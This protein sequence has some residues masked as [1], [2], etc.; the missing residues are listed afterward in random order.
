MIV[1]GCN[2]FSRVSEVFAEHFGSV[3][4]EKHYLLGHDAGASLL[5]DGRLV[6]AV[7]EERLN[8]EKKTTDFPFHSVS[9]CLEQA[10]LRFSDIDL[11][12]IPWNFSPEVFDE[13]LAGIT[14]APMAP[15]AKLDLIAGIGK[16]FTEVVSHDAILAD[17][18]ARTGFTPDPAKVV[19]VPHHL[20]H[21]MT[22]YYLAGMKDSAFLV[23][24]GR[25]EVFSSV[26]GEIRDGRIRVFDESA[27]GAQH[28]IGLLFAA[29]TRYLGFVPNN[30]E[31][32]VMG[33]SGFARPPA[34]NPFLEHLVD[35]REDG[36]YTF[37][38]P[39][40]TDDPRGLDPLF[41]EY[42]GPSQDTLAYRARVAAAVQEMLT[43]VTNH[44]LRALEARTDLNHLLFEG[45][46]A[47]NCLNNTP[48]FEGSRFDDMDVSFG[49]SDTGI[50]IG[51]AVHAWLGHPD[52]SDAQR[53]TPAPVT[54]YLGPEYDD[55]TIERA[56]REFGGR[57]EWTRLNDDEVVDHVAKLL[58]E[59][60]V[61]GWYE[62]R[63]E[64]G[65]RA[66]GHRS[67]L[68]NPRFPDIKD[69]INTRV[70]HREPFRPFAPIVLEPDAPKVFEMGR[71]TRSPY[72]T[73]VFP[74]RP[75]FH[76]VIPG[77]THVDGTSRVQTIT[78]RDT[79]RLAA[80][81]RRFTALTDVPCLLNTSFNVAG[82][83]IVCTPTDALNCFLGT[84][85]DYLVLGNHLVTKA[86]VRTPGRPV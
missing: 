30:D 34:P 29:I 16:L 39:L 84:E 46:V 73:F 68:A 2:G 56:L 13:M 35:L 3:G 40:E 80:L 17:F 82:E 60:V 57:V 32:K 8:R 49:A 86:V 66:L 6:A 20:A 53:S 71:K 43:V 64:H 26:T 79:P 18:A 81:L 7:E 45:G 22:G 11:I 25:A 62:G 47:L 63:I 14:S 42:F 69:V 44:Q 9:W 58:T 52:T 24:D 4:T 54:P 10:G 78:D 28:S 59:K 72:M 76:D 12:A 5:V 55:A 85:I 61:I 65:P 70:K 38:R 37:R 19:F 27:V 51:A 48:L 33:L 15:S 36:R 1:L 77:A 31:Y 50:V 74:V 83:P 21:A 41:E 23:S 67:I 75:E